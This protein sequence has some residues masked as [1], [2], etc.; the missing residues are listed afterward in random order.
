MPSGRGGEGLADEV[1]HVER[2]QGDVLAFAGHPVGQVA[3]LLIAPMRADQVA[4]VDVGVIDVLARLHLRLQFLDDI[5]FADQVMRHL[6]A[7]DLGERLGERLR[8]ILM[9]GDR[10][11]DH[12]DLQALERL[13]GLDEPIHLFHLLVL[14]QSGRLELTVDPFLGRLHIGKGGQASGQHRG[15]RCGCQ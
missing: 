12:L 9:G 10:L 1:V 2:R 3:G 14:G 13:G 5:A 6:D 15:Y 11:R 4:F 8:F 7:G